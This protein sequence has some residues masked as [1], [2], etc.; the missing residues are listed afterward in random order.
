M[1]LKSNLI[2][3]GEKTSQLLV[4]GILKYE[5]QIMIDIHSLK[6]FPKSYFLNYL[7]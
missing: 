6:F 1:S 3:L 2:G 5:R 7:K 4:F